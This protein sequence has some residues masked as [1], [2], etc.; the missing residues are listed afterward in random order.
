MLQ[1]LTSS[2]EIL[3][4]L[5]VLVLTPVVQILWLS[6]ASAYQHFVEWRGRRIERCPIELGPVSIPRIKARLPE[7]ASI[8]CL[9]IRYGSDAY[10]QQLA[11]DQERF[12]G[13]LRLEVETFPLRLDR[14][15]ASYSGEIRLKV[16]RRL[17]TQFK[18][19]F[20][21]ENGRAAARTA[22]MLKKLE[23]VA[24]VSISHYGGKPKV[25][26]LLKRFHIV[27]ST[28]G[29]RRE[30]GPEIRNNFYFPV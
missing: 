24:E 15:N 16:H 5:L 28:D 14:Q 26:F 10:L 29:V 17:G 3:A 18:L 20:E 11:S 7:S 30:G 27:T 19:F 6:G 1:W 2:D 21:V 22:R 25:W 13:R 12:E 4:A 23:S 9:V 8:N